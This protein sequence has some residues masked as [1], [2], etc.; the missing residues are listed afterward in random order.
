MTS[1]MQTMFVH[2]S[3]TQFPHSARPLPAVQS[4]VLAESESCAHLPCLASPDPAYRS[5][6]QRH[7][8]QRFLADGVGAAMPASRLGAEPR[9]HEAYR[10]LGFGLAHIMKQADLLTR[11]NSNARTRQ[12][13]QPQKRAKGTNSWQLKQFAEATLGSG[14]LRKVVQLPEGED[15]DEWLAVNSMSVRKRGCFECCD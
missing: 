14:S 15:R 10:G 11:S 4:N 8:E 5:P 13:F 2:N 9:Q 1:L 12:A 3:P 7:L 6:L